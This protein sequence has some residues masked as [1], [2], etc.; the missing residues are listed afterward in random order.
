VLATLTH[1]LEIHET[2]PDPTS[3]SP[4]WSSWPARCS[5]AG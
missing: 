5:C 4:G 1:D 2:D 3:R